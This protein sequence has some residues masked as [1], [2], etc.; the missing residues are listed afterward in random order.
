MEQLVSWSSAAPLLLL[1]LLFFGI[2][3]LQR[4]LSPDR[5]PGNNDD[6]VRVDFIR[7]PVVAS[8]RN[9][10]PSSVF[11]CV[12]RVFPRFVCWLINVGSPL[13]VGCFVVVIV[14]FFWRTVVVVVV[15]VV[16]RG[17]GGGG[18]GSCSGGSMVAR[19]WPG[20]DQVVGDGRMACRSWGAGS[21]NSDAGCRHDYRFHM[22]AAAA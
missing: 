22:R 20:R 13:R 11:D 7:Q 19:L 5:T 14:T 21:K 9:R 3:F 1:L 6:A 17:G 10:P 18:G 4:W 8:G 16:V 15:V 12:L 2:L